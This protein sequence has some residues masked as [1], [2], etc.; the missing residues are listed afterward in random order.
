MERVRGERERESE[1]ETDREKASERG[2]AV[3]L[4]VVENILVQ[5]GNSL[6]GFWC[7]PLVTVGV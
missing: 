3:L 4:D 2:T 5:G 6:T 7:W 1:K